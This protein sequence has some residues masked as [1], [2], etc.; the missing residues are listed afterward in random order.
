MDGETGDLL[1]G[2][3]IFG[4]HAASAAPDC[5]GEDQ[6]IPEPD[7][8]TILDLECRRDVGGRDPLDAPLSLDD[9]P[10]FLFGQRL[11]QLARSVDAKLLQHLRAENTRAL[12]PQ[13]PKNGLRDVVLSPRVDVVGVDQDVRVD[14]RPDR[15]CH[16]SRVDSI[17]PPRGIP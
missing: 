8:R 11:L 17:R 15:S 16:S 14:E 6:G 1:A 13:V 4:Q 7:P 3:Q 10:G 12:G 2:V 5:D 9:A